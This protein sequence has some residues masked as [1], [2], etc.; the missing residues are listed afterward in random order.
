V[1][2]GEEGEG[3]PGLVYMPFVVMEDLLDKLK[4]LHYEQEFVAELKMRPL[5]RHYFVLQTNPGEQFFM[6]TSLAA[7]LVRK[8]GTR[9]DP[10]QETDD[11]NTT[12][13]NILE[14]LRKVGVTIDFAPS[15]L[16]QGFGEQAIFVLDRLSDE[17]L[18]AAQFHW[19]SP[20]P[21]SDDLPQDEEMEDDAE[22]LLERVEEEMAEEYS[23]EEDG[24]VLHIDEL[25]AFPGNERTGSGSRVQHERPEPYLQSRTDAEA[26]TLEVERVAPSLKVT[27]RVDTRDWRS[28]LEQMHTYRTGIED[29][30]VSTK[31]H[32]DQLQAEIAKTLEKI[33]SREKYVNSQLEP[34]LNEYRQLSQTMAQA[35]EQYKQVSGGVTERSRLL[36]Q[37]TD[38]L[39][40]VK[41]EMEERGSSMTDGSPLVSIRKS[42]ARVKAEIVG[43]DVRV[44]V[45][46][47]SL[48]QAR[49]K[50]R[51]HMQ[52]DL[53]AAAASSFTEAF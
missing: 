2:R 43:M 6:F 52:R 9:F 50:D 34:Q 27:V 42:L 23:E 44:G 1:V 49:L 37:L 35:K 10:P 4:L 30:L 22:L 39:E 38:T 29:S 36:A 48:L 31:T 18:K 5:N 20:I 3:G 45:L 24:D 13:S 17:A 26:W 32:L 28:H 51:H 21:P 33:S 11:P 41:S 47:H 40:S 7:W 12:I 46:E 25:G 14:Q 15:K 19:S 53:Q 16:K 8:A